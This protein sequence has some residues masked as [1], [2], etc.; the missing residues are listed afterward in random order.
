MTAV[1]SMVAVD[2]GDIVAKFFPIIGE[3]R[4]TRKNHS[5]FVF[6]ADGEKFTKFHKFEKL[7]EASGPVRFVGSLLPSR[8]MQESRIDV[9]CMYD[10]E[11]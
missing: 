11:Y 7:P 9:T 10:R 3:V 6:L 5:P 2:S 4:T 1:E 8:Q